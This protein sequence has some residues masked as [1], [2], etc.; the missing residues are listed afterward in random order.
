MRNRG[1]DSR[2]TPKDPPAIQSTW[3]RRPQLRSWL[4]PCSR[5]I[6]AGPPR[7]SDRY[8]EF[9]RGTHEISERRRRHFL[10]HIPSM[11]LQG[12]L[13]DPQFRGCLLVQEAT[14]DKG[15]YFALARRQIE[16]PLPQ[17]SE[18]STIRSFCAILGYGRPDRGHKVYVTEGFG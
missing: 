4:Y 13:T 10:H 9:L 17:R 6:L 14:H 15:Q 3:D 2:R 1:P 7:V 8:P 5:S 11:N 12:H 16:I 18:F